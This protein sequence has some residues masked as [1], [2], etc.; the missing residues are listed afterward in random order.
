LGRGY[1]RPPSLLSLWSSAPFGL[2]NAVGRFRPEATVEARMDSFDDSIRKWLW[3]ETRRG[4]LDRVRE[5]GLPEAYAQ[6]SLEGYVYRTTATSYVTVPLG[7]LPDVFQEAPI[8]ELLDPLVEDGNIRIGPIPAGT[9]VNLI[10]NLRLLS[11]DRNLSAR[12]S[13]ARQLA[14]LVVALVRTLRA[15]P[16]DA[17]DEAARE[18]FAPY[19]DQMMALSTCPDYVVN[20]GHYFGTDR[21]PASEG[22]PGLSDRDKEALIAYL[23]RL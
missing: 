12:L 2:S 22:E 4:D 16:Q 14:E 18:A 20:R 21:L 9:P 17:S 19:V 23:K 7:Y 10:A 13:H 15:L 6:T 3:P 11:E 5:L 8:R 1:I